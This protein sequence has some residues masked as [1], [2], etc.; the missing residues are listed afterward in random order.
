[1]LIVMKPNATA[2]EIDAVVNIVEAVGF[3]AHPMLR[4]HGRGDVYNFA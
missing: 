2:S 3:R 4:A 1:M